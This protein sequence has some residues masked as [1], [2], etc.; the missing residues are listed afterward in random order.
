[1]QQVIATAAEAILLSTGDELISLYTRTALTLNA[2]DV[3]AQAYAA[4]TD[5]FQLSTTQKI[6]AQYRLPIEIDVILHK[7][8]L[9][10]RY[11]N[12]VLQSTCEDFVIRMVSVIDAAFEDIFDV[13][14]VALE[15][16]LPENRR[17][18]KIRGA[19]GSDDTGR[20]EL[21][22]YLI[23]KAELRTPPAKQ[24]TVDMVFDRYCEIR[25]IRN[26]LV[27]N[28]GELG[29]K[30]RARLI[31]LRERLP[32]ALQAG[33]LADAKFL[34]GDQVRI[35]LNEVVLLRNWAYT[36]VLGYLRDAIH[37]SAGRGKGP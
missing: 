21:A 11:R 4:R 1:M 30:H 35:L 12:A 24:S 13:A 22:R 28:G 27:H 19:W 33:S 37:Y 8:E 14:L 5:N 10:D 20:T 34:S 29:L 32:A 16:N 36:T 26:A 9:E 17:V 18:S 23:D 31:A 6:P 3:T 2:F 15:P 7:H 25:E